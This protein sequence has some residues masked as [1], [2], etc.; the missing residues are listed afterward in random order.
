V[1]VPGVYLGSYNAFP[2]GDLFNRE[3]QIHMGQCP[4]KRY[5]EPLLHLIETGRIRPSELITNEMKLGEAPE[6][7]DIFSRREDGVVKIVLK[8]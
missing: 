1:G 7:Y 5:N 2:F 4:V 8:P 6:A 3:I